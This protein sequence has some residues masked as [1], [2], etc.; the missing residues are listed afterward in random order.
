LNNE[1][2]EQRSHNI[3]NK[4]EIISRYV[5]LP[6]T[7]GCGNSGGPSEVKYRMK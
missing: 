3:D 6:H 5:H 2:E 7:E 1:L 4:N